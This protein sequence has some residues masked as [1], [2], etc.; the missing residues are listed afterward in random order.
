MS[1]LAWFGDADRE[2][3]EILAREKL[4]DPGRLRKRAEEALKGNVGDLEAVRTSIDLACNLV[5][6]VQRRGGRR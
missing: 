5:A 6:A 2:D 4:I 1:K 3:L